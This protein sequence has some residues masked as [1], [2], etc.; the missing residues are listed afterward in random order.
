M[1]REVVSE[2]VVIAYQDRLRAPEVL[3]ELRRR[4]WEWLADLENAVVVMRDEDGKIGIQFS[5]NDAVSDWQAWTRVWSA[6]LTQ[7][8]LEPVGPL[9]ALSS[10]DVGWWTRTIGIS[11]S[12]VRDVGSL[13]GPG[14]SAILMLLQTPISGADV[15]RLRNYGGTLLHTTLNPGQEE[16]LKAALAAA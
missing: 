3:L 14:D 13:L 1:K 16:V 10:I 8:L 15:R 11:D 2:L 6:F 12:F 9:P 4:D 7:A 5:V